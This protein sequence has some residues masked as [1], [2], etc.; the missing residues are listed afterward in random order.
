MMPTATSLLTFR[1]TVWKISTL[2]Y[3]ITPSKVFIGI[4]GF[5][6]A[7]TKTLCN[8]SDV[9]V[10][11]STWRRIL[12][13]QVRKRLIC[14]Y[15]RN[16]IVGLLVA[17]S[18]VAILTC[19][20]VVW[21][22]GKKNSEE[23]GSGD[24]SEEES[25]DEEESEGEGDSNEGSDSG[26]GDEEME[27]GSNAGDSASNNEDVDSDADDDSEA[28]LSD[29][30]GSAASLDAEYEK[31]E[32]DGDDSDD[33]DIREKP[34]AKKDANNAE[35]KRADQKQSTVKANGQAEVSI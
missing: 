28:A 5:F 3:Y 31:E 18:G 26:S 35:S 23:D 21:C 20:C 24:G 12:S 14:L 25:G 19:A 27:A 15:C 29:I 4:H 16:T 6:I 32:V 1:L 8:S 22:L 7:F 17:Y 11:A 30:E 13:Q 9:R 33:V 34:S 2:K 10:V